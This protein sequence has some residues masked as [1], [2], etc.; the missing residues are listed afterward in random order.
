MVSAGNATAS[1]LVG[2]LFKMMA[3]VNMPP[4]AIGVDPLMTGKSQV[5]FVPI[6]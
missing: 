6:P 4:G 5:F 3:A 2:E 1:H